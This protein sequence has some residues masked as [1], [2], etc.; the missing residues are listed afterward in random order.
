L[1]D[2]HVSECCYLLLLKL[3][4]HIQLVRIVTLTFFN[5]LRSEKL[6]A[7]RLIEFMGS[8]LCYS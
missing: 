4:N 1:H 7:S 6:S 3:I 2:D 5:R 8:S